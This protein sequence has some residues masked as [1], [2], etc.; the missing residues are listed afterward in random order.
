MLKKF[1][2]FKQ[3]YLINILVAILSS[4][5][6]SLLAL[7]FYPFQKEID[8]KY[9]FSQQSSLESKEKVSKKIQLMNEYFDAIV[10]LN[11][12]SEKAGFTKSP[13]SYSSENYECYRN[14]KWKII[15]K[16][17]EMILYFD[18][19]DQVNTIL[20]NT[21]SSLDL[22]TYLFDQKTNPTASNEGKLIFEKK[23]ES[24]KNILAE[25]IGKIYSQL[26][27]EAEEAT[28]H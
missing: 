10:G 15:S 18:N 19:I 20:A 26:K 5:F 22:G 25:T 14:Y 21:K 7:H 24:N 8:Q 4:I 27:Q 23:Y 16:E 17:A 6:G 28:K 2:L 12:C 1:N 9:W 11:N 3:T 13:V